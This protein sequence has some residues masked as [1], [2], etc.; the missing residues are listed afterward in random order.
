MLPAN[1]YLYRG[2]AGGLSKYIKSGILAEDGFI[3]LHVGIPSEVIITR[4]PLTS[5]S[6]FEE[7]LKIE[8][9]IKDLF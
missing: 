4:F 9:K 5:S 1:D 7:S 8:A 3:I 6:L 2:A